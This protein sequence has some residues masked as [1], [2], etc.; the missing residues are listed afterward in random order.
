MTQTGYICGVDIHFAY[1][2]ELYLYLRFKHNHP[3][4]LRFGEA[5]KLFIL[6][7]GHWGYV[8]GNKQMWLRL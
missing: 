8:F 7:Q 4:F 3:V 5:T 2:D 6:G 1:S